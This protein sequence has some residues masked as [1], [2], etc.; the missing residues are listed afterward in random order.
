M[1]LEISVDR[2]TPGSRRKA[3]SP[4]PRVIGGFASNLVFYTGLKLNKWQNPR[5]GKR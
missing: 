3:T 4:D 1:S 5:Q 2:K